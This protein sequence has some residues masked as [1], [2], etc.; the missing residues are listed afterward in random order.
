MTRTK[1]ITLSVIAI[2]AL[3]ATTAY[4]FGPERGGKGMWGHGGGMHKGMRGGKKLF[5]K[6]D[7]DKDG[8]VTR[9]EAEAGRDKQFAKMDQNSDGV[10]SVAEIDAII[11][12]RMRRMQIRM[13]Y[14]M[15]GKMDSNGDGQVAKAE[16]DKKAMAMFERADRDGDGQVTR[17]EARR[18]HRGRGMR[19]RGYGHHMKHGKGGYMQGNKKPKQ[20]N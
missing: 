7:T 10:V 20:S 2:V 16:F 8:I 4:A 11:E 17:K 13:R 18:M 3:G 5:K 6:L 19:H 14:K 9:Q 15:L 12:K 1:K